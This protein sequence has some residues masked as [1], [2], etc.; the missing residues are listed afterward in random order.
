MNTEQLGE[1][2]VRATAPVPRPDL[3]SAALS[4]AAVVRRRRSA[5]GATTAVAAVVVAIAVGVSLGGA[6]PDGPITPPPSPPSREQTTTDG[7][8]PPAIEE[9]VVQTRWDPRG[10]ISLPTVDVGLPSSLAPPAE[11][12]PLVGMARA[13][14]LIDDRQRLFV[15]DASG[16]WQSLDYPEKPIAD[17]SDPAVLTVDG[18]RV[19]FAGRTSVWSREVRGGAWQSVTYPDEFV[20]LAGYGVQ[21]VPDAPDGLWMSRGRRGRTWYADLAAG[22]M[23]ERDVALGTATTAG[24]R[25]MVRLGV[26]RSAPV[27]FMAIGTPGA[28]EQTWRTDDLQA[29]TAPAADS[30][31]VAAV[32]GVGGWSGT[33]GPTEQNGLIA[34]RLDDL[35][36]RAYLPVPDPNYWYTDAGQL[37]AL[38][39]LDP[40]TVLGS[41]V[42]QDTGGVDTGTRYLF[43]W[44]VVTGELRLAAALP[45]R[46]GLSLARE[47]LG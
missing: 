47:G 31:S 21:L 24:D 28:D 29:L 33:R 22:S 6:A 27:R 37:A 23:V 12:E 46:W 1:V 42:P 7:P 45:A 40:D 18:S 11:T 16:T 30:N 13:L 19:V 4:R 10:V 20:A 44:D 38:S 32:R 36:T 25:G 17:Y 9:S 43:T 5:L 8:T 2:L 14:A 34:L 3:A 39:W 15:V 41:V 26:V 35:A